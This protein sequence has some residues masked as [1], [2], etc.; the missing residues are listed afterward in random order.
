[1][2]SPGSLKAVP[3]MV[4]GASGFLGSHLVDALVSHGASVTASS[5]RLH[6]PEE[7]RPGVRW[8]K[9]DLT[10]VEMI[11]RHIADVRPSCIY[12]LSSLADGRPSRDL[13]LP[14]F[15]A[16]AVASVNLLT[17]CSE[18]E[19][20]RIVLAGSLETPAAD[21]IPLS[22]YAAAKAVSHL[23]ARTF[24][25]LY[26]LPVVV[27][28]IFMTY[29]PRQP[30]SKVIPSVLSMIARGEP[31]LVRSPRRAVDWVYVSDVVDGLVAMALAPGIEGRTIDLGSGT[32]VTIGQ[33][34]EMLCELTGSG[35]APV[36]QATD[37]RVERVAVA[38]IQPAA[39]LLKWHPRVA[40]RE[41]LG[42]TIAAFRQERGA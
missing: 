13:I 25:H 4:T 42:R 34:V 24:Y 14:T 38:D 30:L 28:R 35:L 23:Y 18:L 3:V 32:L 22:P 33:V 27:A 41:G 29:G 16:E 20:P 39:E 12:H 36:F 26:R 10:D 17:V 1:M 7:D 15:H 5:R 31:P 6:S 37:G 8:I 40:L 21:E 11:R 2:S 9:I 19:V